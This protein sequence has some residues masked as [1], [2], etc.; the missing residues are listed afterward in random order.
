MKGSSNVRGF[1][2]GLVF[3]LILALA[4]CPGLLGGH[5]ACAKEPGDLRSAIAWVA[6]KTKPSVVHI[7]V[8]Q[9]QSSPNSYRVP[10]SAPSFGYFL[11]SPRVWG[12]F[13]REFKGSGT[14]IIIDRQG[15]ILTNNHIVAGATGIHVQLPGGEQYEGKLVGSDP[16]TDLAVIR[17][18]AGRSLPCVIF[19]DSDK[20]EV[21]EWV[22][23]IGHAR[24]SGQ[25]VAQGIISAEHRRGAMA[26]NSYMDLLQTDI[27]IN[28]SNSGGP[29]LNLEGKVIGISTLLSSRSPDLE[30][31]GFAIP[32]NMALYISK[33]LLENGKVER[34]WLGA[35]ILDLTPEVARSLSVEKSNG[36]LIAD[37]EKGGPAEKAGIRRGDI[38]ISYEGKPVSD[39]ESLQNMVAITPAGSLRK[40]KV[41][42]QGK[43]REVVV[44]IGS[45]EQAAMM[46]ASSIKKLLGV[47]VRALT[48]KEVER[49]DLDSRQGVAI[50]WL[51]PEGPLGRAGFESNDML[52]EINGQQIRS[53]DDFVALV[54]SL[55]PSQRVL[56]LGVDHRTG[57]T[58]YVQ[59]VVP[60]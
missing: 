48:G 36:V 40:I 18:R 13:R 8:I 30:G 2:T 46:R 14:G 24:P 23:A 31:V 43:V 10:G 28:L 3:G 22:V 50:A 17:I 42:R 29:L 55:R 12:G 33:Q 26:P 38:L 9:P 21:G 20:V 58:G 41:L 45:L 52:L 59:I 37:L 25:T 27:P 15:Y 56:L 1:S 49:Y 11:E 51:D 6:K 16:P 7:E 47:D 35:S 39:S 57:R 53:P 54:K 34:G 19:G 32:S 44:R 60:W 5:E 4:L